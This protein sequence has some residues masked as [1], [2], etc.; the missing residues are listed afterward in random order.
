MATPKKIVP[1]PKRTKAETEQEFNEMREELAEARET[2]EPKAEEVRK[3]RETET[4]AAVEG[5][6]VETVVGEVSNL[7]L[8]VS[9]SLAALSGQLVQE[10]NRL[11]NV[12]EA[13]LL[14]QKE[15]ERLHKIDVAATAIDQLIQ[16]YSR[17][18]DQLEAEIAVQ[19]A[20][21]AEEQKQSERE[22]KE[23]EETL[24]KQRQREMDEYEYRKALERKKAQDKYEE[25]MKLQERANK[26]K[27]ETLEK[28]WREREA[29]LKASEEE[30]K[31]LRKEAAEFPARL[32]R[33]SEKAAAEAVRGAEQKSEQRFLILSKDSEGEKRLAE[34]RIKTL[35]EN[36]TRQSAQMAALEKQLE[37]AKRQVQEIAVKAIEGASG[38][39][40]LSHI[41]EIAM[42]QAK[43]RTPQG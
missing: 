2:L 41:N 18:K 25:E 31:S 43:H 7:G 28:S 1:R 20:T 36:L 23:Q 11:A 30:L 10:V 39:R 17:Q 29:T 12:R 35:E 33:E 13:V 27:Q 21:W 37:E 38:A 15:L 9:K 5:L 4:R 40:A 14:E 22:R 3:A 16:D 26:E 32:Q 19:R 34:L 24:K 42:E 6:S 8:D